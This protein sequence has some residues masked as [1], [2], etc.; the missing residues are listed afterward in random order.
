MNALEKY[1]AKKKLAAKL[2]ESAWKLPKASEVFA[3]FKNIFTGSPAA[4]A[5]AK[6]QKG[7]KPHVTLSRTQ[8]GINQAGGMPYKRLSK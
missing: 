3:G 1:A 4:N 2:K 6:A 8:R 5:K 7:L